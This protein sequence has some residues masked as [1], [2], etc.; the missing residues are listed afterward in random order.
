M[1]VDQ[2]YSDMAKKTI[3]CPVCGISVKVENVKAHLRKVHPGK[4]VDTEDLDLPKVKKPKRAKGPPGVKVWQILTALIVV[5][6]VIAVAVVLTLPPEEEEEPNYA[7]NI[8]VNDVYGVHYSLNSQIGYQPILIQFFDPAG[9]TCKDQASVLTNLSAHFGYNL[10]MLSLSYR[11]DSEVK[12]FR[13]YYGADW[14]FA[15]APENVISD[16]G[17]T[18]HPHYILLDTKGIIRWEHTGPRLLQDFIDVIG[19]WT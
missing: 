8:E 6:I 18:G 5:I 11:V 16:Y 9:Q 15:H 12:Y 3:E 2:S 10:K 17:V 19:P 1:D 4:K 14:I 7:P 13:E